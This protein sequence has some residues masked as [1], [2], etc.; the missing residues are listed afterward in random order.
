MTFL[1][2]SA[3]LFS[4]VLGMIGRLTIFA[5]I[6]AMLYEVVARYVFGA[7]TLWAFDIS[8]MLNGSVFLLGAA[9]SLREDAHVR[10]D[11]LSQKFPVRMQQLLNGLIY[12][13]IMAPIAFAFAWVAG[14]KAAKAFSNGEV[15]AVSPWAPLVWPFYAVIAIGL[16]AFALQFVI[17]ALKFCL[18]ERS[19]G[20]TVSEIQEMEV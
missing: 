17:E 7:P 19:P 4:I 20:D 6:I 12:L 9:F 13:L 5:L 15:E 18:G 1:R 10:I 14:S 11:F 3:E 16:W 8:Y 2:N